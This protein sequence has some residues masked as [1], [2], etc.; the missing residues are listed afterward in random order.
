MEICGNTRV[1][2]NRW[3]RDDGDERGVWLRGRKCPCGTSSQCYGSRYRPLDD[4]WRNTVDALYSGSHFCCI[5]QL[6][7]R[8]GFGILAGYVHSYVP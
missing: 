3:R 1:G 2:S 6:A 7:R 8:S 5:A 4:G